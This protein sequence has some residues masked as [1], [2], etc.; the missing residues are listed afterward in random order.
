MKRR[1]LK[2]AACT[3]IASLAL[4]ATACGSKTAKEADAKVE[5]TADVQADNEDDVEEVE[6]EE[7]ENEAESAEEDEEAVSLGGSYASL[8]DFYNDPAIKPALDGM[9]ESMAQEGMSAA[10][11]V[12]GNEFKV[13]IKIEDSSMIVDGMGEYLDQTLEAM[14]PTFEAQVAQFDDAIGEAGACTVVMCYTD[15]DDNVLAEKAFKAQ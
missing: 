4:A 3:V 2:V 7:A 12:N 8:E 5:D 13:I 14:A 11:E 15:P 10:L 1:T 9:F 6:V